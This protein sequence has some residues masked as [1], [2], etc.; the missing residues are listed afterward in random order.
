MKKHYSEAPDHLRERAK[1]LC[2]SRSPART[3]LDYLEF[4][5]EHDYCIA[6][7]DC[8]YPIT[9]ALDSR[10]FAAI[11]TLRKRNPDFEL[12]Y[13]EEQ[14]LNARVNSTAYQRWCGGPT[15]E[16]KLAENMAKR[17]EE[18]RQAAIQEKIRELTIAESHKIAARIAAQ[19]EKLVDVELSK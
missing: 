18:R 11:A 19:A 17:A 4:Y 15:A 12:H 2:T 10:D 5:F 8:Q 9:A 7:Q 3:M 14:I 13:V 1:A 6:P 16:A